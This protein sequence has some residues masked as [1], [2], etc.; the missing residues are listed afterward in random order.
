M[1]RIVNRGNDNM[2]SVHTRVEYETR[3]THIRSE[4][5]ILFWAI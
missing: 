5:R 1:D 3:Q 2:H 4:F